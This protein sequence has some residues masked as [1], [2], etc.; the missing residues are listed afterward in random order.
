M[1]INS[2]FSEKLYEELSDQCYLVIEEGKISALDSAP[3]RSFLE[4]VKKF[5]TFQQDENLLAINQKFQEI[6]PHLNDPK[7]PEFNELYRNLSAEQELKLSK[8]FGH[9]AYLFEQGNVKA[10]LTLLALKI[11]NFFRT[12]FGNEKIEFKTYLPI[13]EIP[14][15]EALR[16][17]VNGEHQK[18]LAKCHAINDPVPICGHMYDGLKQDHEWTLKSAAEMDRVDDRA[19]IIPPVEGD[20]PVANTPSADD[21]AVVAASDVSVEIAAAAAEAV[22]L[23]APTTEASM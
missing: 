4:R 14:C 23:L 2:P 15:F 6:A 17:Q 13:P 11:V 12:L 1:S 9:I 5:F 7:T 19:V 10:S 3:P 18:P 16:A 21:K 8:N 22:P 20:K